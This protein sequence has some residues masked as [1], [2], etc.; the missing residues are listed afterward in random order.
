M[1]LGLIRLPESGALFWESWWV[2]LLSQAGWRW[3]FLFNVPIG[4]LATIWGLPDTS[5]S[6]YSTK[7]AYRLVRKPYLC[8]RLNDD[9]GSL[10]LWYQ[11]QRSFFDELEQLHSC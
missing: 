3:V 8:C 10:D 6:G 7:G 1:A 4:L 9:T 2:G 11:S 5:R